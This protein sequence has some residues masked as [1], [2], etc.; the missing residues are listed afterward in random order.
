MSYNTMKLMNEAYHVR[1]SEHFKIVLLQ[2]EE[3]R[4]S[5]SEME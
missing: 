5:N 1:L 4:L 2:P 3:V